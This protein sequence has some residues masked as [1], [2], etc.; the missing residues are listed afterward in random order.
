M[1]KI[2]SLLLTA[3]ALL[4]LFSFAGCSNEK[5]EPAMIV[6][7]VEIPQGVLNYYI[8]AGKDYLTSYGINVEDEES[9]ALYMSMIEEQGVDIVTEIAVVRSLAKE[10]NLQ[11]AD[12]ALA[13]ALA[14]EKANFGDDAS[15][16]AW[17]ES[18]GLTESD[19]EWILEYQLLS[20]ALY[21]EL[22]ADLTLPDDEVAEIYNADP[23][24]YDTYKFA[25]ILVA[26]DESEA[27]PEGATEPD[28]TAL[29]KLWDDAKAT[30]EDLIAQINNGD[31]TFEDLA[32]RYNTDS[33]SSTGGD[34]GQYVTKE[35]SPYVAEFTDAAFTLT[36]IGQIT[37]EPVRSSFGYHVIKLLD[38]TTGVGEA[39]AAIIEEQLG[40]ERYARYSEAVKEAMENVTITKDYERQY[41]YEET[42]DAGDGEADNEDIENNA[43]NTDNT[44]EPQETAAQ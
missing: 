19:V 23:D 28:E 10:H 9:G 5:A 33:T 26:V 43:G 30:A 34:L 36:E 6:N 21:E 44:D 20:D 1:K 41:A 31:A 29:A 32:S 3:T 39:R 17:L 15:W 25:H 24:K 14:N 37:A 22:N 35:N 8:N 12:G 11:L 42:P 38:K 16:Q 40:E 2:L 27:T 7:D 13:D 18:Y 4:M